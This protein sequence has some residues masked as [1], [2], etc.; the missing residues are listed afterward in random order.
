MQK[1][2]SPGGNTLQQVRYLQKEKEK[3]SVPPPLNP[4]TVYESATQPVD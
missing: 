1:N 3:K 4:K 2:P